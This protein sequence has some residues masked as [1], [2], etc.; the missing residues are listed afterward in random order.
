M[1]AT[2]A[3]DSLEAEFIKAGEDKKRKVQ[4]VQKN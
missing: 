3:E 2:G 1:G 4:K